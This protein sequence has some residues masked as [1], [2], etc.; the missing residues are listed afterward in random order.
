[1]LQRQPEE[2]G[3]TT[4]APSAPG[5]GQPS[6]VEEFEAAEEGHRLWV[7][8]VGNSSV[9]MVASDPKTLPQQLRAWKKAADEMKPSSLKTNILEW[10]EKTWKKS[11]A[12]EA[13]AK[14]A[15]L[16]ERAAKMHGATAELM[17]MLK[18]LFWAFKLD[19]S[20]GVAVYRGI[21]FT[22]DWNAKRGRTVQEESAR[23]FASVKAEGSYSAATWELAKGLAAPR[24]VTPSHLESANRIVMKVI[25]GWKE[26]TDYNRQDTSP[27]GSDKAKA[28]MNL[29]NVIGRPGMQD[30]LDKMKG[31]FTQGGAKF[32]NQFA[33]ALS[34]YI[35]NQ[36]TF[37][38]E[39]AKQ[40]DGTY[41]D[42]PFKE[43]PFVST[44]K[45][46]K[47]AVKY[48]Q[49]KLASDDQ[50]ST[51]GTVG[52]VLV[53]VA[54]RVDLLEAGG[55]D[56]WQQLGEGKLRFTTW[57]MAENEITFSGK[58]PDNFLRAMTPV[59]GGQTDQ[60]VAKNQ[61]IGASLAQEAA[62]AAA[63]PFGGL[64]PP[65]VNKELA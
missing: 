58:I 52:R 47:E 40:P 6:E 59:Q 3:G 27:I 24:A 22:Q 12:L 64:R 14:I 30:L 10:I 53:Y 17:E 25:E 20:G 33:A 16:E 55:I 18:R 15:D 54:D 56:V 7:E 13:A 5:P 35:D 39:L 11:A 2:P 65:E 21:H 26:T 19:L 44:S 23:D 9:I 60:E 49:G 43:I 63:V 29:E 51:A 57:R 32:E 8:Q 1:M 42:V 41:K 28:R 45:V 46:A 50:K 34:R 38:A 48:A 37:E 36:A 4:P 61:E 31:T 62:A